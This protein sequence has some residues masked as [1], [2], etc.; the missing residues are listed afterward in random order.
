MDATLLKLQLPNLH[1]TVLFLEVCK[2]SG[3]TS[4][5]LVLDNYI[6]AYHTVDKDHVEIL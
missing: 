5:R 2:S 3:T 1:P 6:L 4:K